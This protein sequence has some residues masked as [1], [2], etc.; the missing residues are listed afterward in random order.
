IRL[1]RQGSWS[2]GFWIYLLED[3]TDSYRP[4]FYKGH[5]DET[6]RT[7]SAWL[8]PHSNRITLRVT[9]NT[10]PDIGIESSTA[11][12]SRSW[13]HVA[14]SFNNKTERAFSATIFVN[15]AVD[16]SGVFKDM[17]VIDNTGPMYIGRDPS[18]KGS[19]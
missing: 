11:L 19:R 15:G 18:N 6:G 16:V 1:T 14:F 12:A 10:N 8:S 3:P 2:L 4:L 17:D 5:G 13:Y 7:P 9:T